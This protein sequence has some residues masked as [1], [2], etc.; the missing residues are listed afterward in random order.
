MCEVCEFLKCCMGLGKAMGPAGD[1][2]LSEGQDKY[3]RAGL[4]KQDQSV[5]QEVPF[6]EKADDVSVN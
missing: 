1:L 6:L 3:F 2:C 4:V 5:G